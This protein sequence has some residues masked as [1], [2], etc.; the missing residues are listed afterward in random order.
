LLRE[1]KYLREANIILFNSFDEIILRRNGIACDNEVS[2]NAL[3]YIIAGH[4]AYHLNIL[5]GKYLNF[6]Y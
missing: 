5:K 1:F 3:I 6:L 2:L 4:T